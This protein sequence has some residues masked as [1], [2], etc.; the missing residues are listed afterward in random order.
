MRSVE[1]VLFSFCYT[2][3]NHAQ[4]NFHKRILLIFLQVLIFCSFTENESLKNQFHLLVAKAR[5]QKS[6]S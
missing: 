2:L 1:P 3:S 6:E 5:L 4:T